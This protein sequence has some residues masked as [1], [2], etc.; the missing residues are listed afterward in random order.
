MERQ[1]NSSIGAKQ[2]SVEGRK[3]E[4]K[5]GI[6]PPYP[7]RSKAKKKRPRNAERHVNANISMRPYV[8]RDPAGEKSFLSSR[9]H[10]LL[11]WIE[12]SRSGCRLSVHVVQKQKF[13]P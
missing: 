2:T 4:T 3:V 11:T 5:S 9:D 8:V 13:A 10:Y 7:Y 12:R 1:D 6:S